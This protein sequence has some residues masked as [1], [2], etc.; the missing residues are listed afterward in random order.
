MTQTI[1]ATQRN[2]A[3]WLSYLEAIHPTSIDMGLDRTHDVFT[4]LSLDFRNQPIVTVA[5]T[6]GKGTTCRTLEALALAKRLNVA[7][8][9][10][11]HILDFRE[12]VRV[13]DQ[14]LT[15]SDFCDA[16]QR[17]EEARANTSLTYFEFT[18]LAAFV[19][20]SE[21]DVD[22]V[23]LEV[24]LGGRLDAVNIVDPAV[25]VITTIDLDHQDWLGDTRAKVASEKAG[26]LRASIPAVI[27]E[28]DPPDTLIAEV[29]R[30]DCKAYWQGKDFGFEEKAAENVVWQTD[31]D[32]IVIPECAIPLQ[33]IATAIAAAKAL[34]WSIDQSLINT[35]LSN[36]AL[37]GRC[38]TLQTTPTIM[39]D[40]AHNPQATKYLCEQI[41]KHAF[42]QLHLV[43]GMLSDKDSQASLQ[44]F[45]NLSA[46]WYLAEVISPRS[47]SV[48]V[49]KSS[50][51]NEPDVMS[52][53]S[54][55]DGLKNAIEEAVEGDLIVAFG[56]FFTVAEVFACLGKQQDFKQ[57]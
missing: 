22:L 53:S 14:L 25:A 42:Q 43:C 13:N 51:S 44:P 11:P 8:Y 21:A 32:N 46:K 18:T 30:L 20:M 37:P 3:E 27:G 47:A 29:L 6:N 38:Q 50:L 16:F 45:C 39:V 24:G 52:F 40:V 33:N 56:S 15:E 41:K 10:S 4:R 49:L 54:I 31:S 17:V 36:V 9:S 12:R 1:K 28:I 2:L 34:D 7:V 48:E 19:L 55:T 35:A 26:I 5:G 23:I 57:E